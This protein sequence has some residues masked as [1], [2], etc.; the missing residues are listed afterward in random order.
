MAVAQMENIECEMRLELRT[1]LP[2]PEECLLRNIM[3]EFFVVESTDD[4]PEADRLVK[5][6]RRASLSE[7]TRPPRLI[8]ITSDSPKAWLRLPSFSTREHSSQSGMG[9]CGKVVVLV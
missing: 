4:V 3:S 2:N 7:S 6:S 9:A 1:M 5:E 8:E